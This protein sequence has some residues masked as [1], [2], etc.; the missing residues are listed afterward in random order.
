[1][2]NAG[3][4]YLGENYLEEAQE[5]I[6]QFTDIPDLE[7]HMIGHVQ[8]RK[9]AG[10]G[11]WFDWVEAVDNIK[12]ATRLSRFLTDQ[13]KVMPVLLECNVSGETTKYGYPAWD[14]SQWGD[15]LPELKVMIQ[16]PGIQ[17]KGLMTIAP[18][19]ADPESARPYFAR[20]SRLRAFLRQALPECSWT[21]L[22]MGMSSDYGV[23]IQEGATIVRIGTAIMGSRSG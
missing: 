17:V 5:K 20:L 19:S 12:L 11:R 14:E 2:I 13:N 16:L 3:A 18:Y 8:S 21:E 1:V 7:W 15:L 4:R 22:S 23:A 9:A 6:S 10:V